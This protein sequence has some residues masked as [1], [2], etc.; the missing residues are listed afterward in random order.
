MEPERG[1]E[2][3]YAALR[4]RWGQLKKKQSPPPHQKK[5]NKKTRLYINAI[6]GYLSNKELIHKPRRMLHDSCRCTA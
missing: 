6:V 2:T 5:P 4:E 3:F 1:N